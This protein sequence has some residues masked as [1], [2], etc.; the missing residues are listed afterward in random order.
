VGSEVES[1]LSRLLRSVTAFN[2]VFGSALEPALTA[3][4]SCSDSQPSAATAQA[5]LS[6]ATSAPSATTSAAASEAGAAAPSTPKQSQ[7]A[8]PSELLSSPNPFQS[9]VQ[10]GAASAGARAG[11]GVPPPTANLN[12]GLTETALAVTQLHSTLHQVYFCTHP[13]SHPTPHTPI[14]FALFALSFV[15]DA[16][17]RWL[18]YRF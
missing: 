12:S 7:R 1:V 9:P 16:S 14:L 11:A 4:V 13:H 18:W 17:L 15:C 6:T 3:Y 10:S 8:G 2:A 5:M